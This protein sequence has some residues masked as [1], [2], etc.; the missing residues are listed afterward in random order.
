MKLLSPPECFG[1]VEPGIYR[2]NIPHPTAFDFITQLK[3]KSFVILS[4]ATPLR[5]V[6]DFFASKNIQLVHLGLKA[7]KPDAGW[8]PVSEELMKE[9]LEFI[10]N[11]E[12]HPV[13]VACTSGIHQTGTLVGCLRKLQSWNMNS[14][15]NEVCWIL[16]PHFLLIMIANLSIYLYD[17]STVCM[18]V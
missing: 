7:W 10:L 15:L 13:L 12:T 8:K 5:A 18:L 1:I 17:F 16:S 14:I 3:L 11:S 9:A 6:S 2:S 4:P